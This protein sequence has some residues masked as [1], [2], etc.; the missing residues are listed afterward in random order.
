MAQTPTIDPQYNIGRILVGGPAVT[1][2]SAEAKPPAAKAATGRSTDSLMKGWSDWMSE[3][4]PLLLQ[5]GVDL[6]QPPSPGQSLAGQ[7]G[8][9]VGSGLEAQDR[10][11]VQNEQT[12]QQA[13]ENSRAERKLS[14]EEKQNAS[15][16]ELR[17]A[18]AEYYRAG[19]KR[20]SILNDQLKKE[21]SATRQIALLGNLWAK[22][23]DQADLSGDE[24]DKTAA[25]EAY[26]EYIAAIQASRAGRASASSPQ[27]PGGGGVN[28][29]DDLITR[30]NA[31]IAATPAY[32]DALIAKAKQIASSRGIVL[33]ETKI[34]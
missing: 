25:D 24:E 6:L 32:R 20:T 23:K 19:G 8:A 16:A 3:N 33:D 31:Q 30:L 29:A 22:L 15:E 5:M 2:S 14:N 13:I 34:K 7:V 11:R 12:R 18:Q 1:D 21:D 4:R 27:A 17:S 10:Q 26:S 9:A 28:G